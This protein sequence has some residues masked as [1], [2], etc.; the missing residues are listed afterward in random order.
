MVLP[1]SCELRTYDSG[2]RAPRRLDALLPLL[3]KTSDMLPRLE[4]RERR[5]KC[6]R[7]DVLAELGRG[8]L[9]STWIVLHF[10]HLLGVL[11]VER[12]G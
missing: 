8:E 9:A 1:T 5:L 3:R 11:M 10:C 7:I 6:W 2:P 4:V 12:R